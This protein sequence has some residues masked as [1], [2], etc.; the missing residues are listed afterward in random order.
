MRQLKGVIAAVVFWTATAFAQQGTAD[1]RGKVV[2]QQGA[3]LPGV[4]LVARHQDS[5]LFRET[6]SGSDG[7]FFLSA[8]TPGR[9]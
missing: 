3:A 9:L 5:G 7:S 4:A 1:L 8:M 2:D 6:V